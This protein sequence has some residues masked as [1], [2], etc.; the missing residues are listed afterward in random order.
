ME[1][2]TKK[3]NV[4]P[5]DLHGWTFVVL[6]EQGMRYHAPAIVSL[7]K[8]FGRSNVWSG[9]GWGYMQYEAIAVNASKQLVEKAIAACSAAWPQHVVEIKVKRR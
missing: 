5:T 3:T 7:R 9:Y 6:S 4:Q 8:T 2:T 1:K